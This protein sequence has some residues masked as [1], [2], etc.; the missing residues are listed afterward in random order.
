[1]V[2]LPP[3]LALLNGL[4]GPE[5]VL[6]FVIVLVLFGGEKLPEF[7]R[8]A[9]KVLREF[10]KAAAGVEEE[11]KRALEEDDRKK[12][13]SPP[14]PT[15]FPPYPPGSQPP[16]FVPPNLAAAAPPPAPIA[17]EPPA[18]PPT[19]PPPKTEPHS[20]GPIENLP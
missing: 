9:G 3:S 10:K 13:G 4:G 2:L 11:F 20:P 5:V 12:S 7:A 17:Q 16:A 1:M 15:K 18:V 14:L 8:G 19:V 6:V